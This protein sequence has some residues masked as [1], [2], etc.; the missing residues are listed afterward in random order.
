MLVK[1]KNGSLFTVW[2]PVPLYNGRSQ[3]A[4]GVWTGARTPYVFTVLNKREKLVSEYKEIETDEKA[5]FCYCAIH[6]TE[7][8]DVLLGYCAGGAEDGACLKII[9]IRKFINRILTKYN[10]MS[11]F[12]LICTIVLYRQN[13]ASKPVGSSGKKTILR[14]YVPLVY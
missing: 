13:K 4:E 11:I 5:G 14:Q 3:Y 9:R 10:Y 12:R 1:L 2:N 6:E 8:G 7:N